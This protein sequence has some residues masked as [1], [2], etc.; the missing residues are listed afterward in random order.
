MPS[1]RSAALIDAIADGLGTLGKLPVH[2]VLA[3]APGYTGG[4]QADQAN[5]AH[6]VLNVWERFVID[7]A[8]LPDTD[9]RRGPVLLIDDEVDSRWTLT[10]AAFRLHE[11]GLGPVLPFVLRTR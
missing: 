4:F 10:V 11:A 6:Q 8:A 7:S 1:R 5:S 2:R 3:E 9:V